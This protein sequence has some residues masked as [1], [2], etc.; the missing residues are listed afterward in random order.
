MGHQTD[1]FLQRIS[2]CGMNEFIKQA[3]HEKAIGRSAN[4][5]PGTDG[6]EFGSAIDAGAEIFDGIG[7]V[8]GSLRTL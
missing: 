5:T 8:P 1:A 6:Q 4:R 2:A 3:F 7:L